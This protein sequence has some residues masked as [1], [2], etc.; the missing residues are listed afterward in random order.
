MASNISELARKR[1]YAR[2]KALIPKIDAHVNLLV[3]LVADKDLPVGLG[4]THAPTLA[5]HNSYSDKTKLNIQAGSQKLC[6]KHGTMT[7]K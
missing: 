1:L 4:V 6:Q 3:G 2:T 7:R 5:T